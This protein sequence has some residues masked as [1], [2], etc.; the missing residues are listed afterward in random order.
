MALIDVKNLAVWKASLALTKDIEALTESYP[1]DEKFALV[2][3]MNR[4]ARAISVHLVDAA[5]HEITKE[6]LHYLNKAIHATTELLTH[7]ILSQRLG[8]I[9]TTVMETYEKKIVSVLTMLKAF[10]SK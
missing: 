3:Q 2:S 1:E 7:T 8:I 5:N 6:R 9:T 10:N 4:E